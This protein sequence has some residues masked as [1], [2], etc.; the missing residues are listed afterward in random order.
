MHKQKPKT[1]PKKIRRDA[2]RRL[3][4][5]LTIDEVRRLYSAALE[6][7]APVMATR[8]IDMRGGI[9]VAEAEALVVL[10]NIEAAANGSLT[11][12]VV[13]T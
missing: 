6:A 13:E 12:V 5:Q 10:V 11:R 4:R 3:N 2:K 8:I 1:N 9:S 7:G